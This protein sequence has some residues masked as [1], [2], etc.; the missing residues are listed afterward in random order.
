VNPDVVNDAFGFQHEYR[1]CAFDS[2]GH[3]VGAG[4]AVAA[5]SFDH[6]AA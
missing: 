5:A 3:E 6:V 1:L 4:R 2:F